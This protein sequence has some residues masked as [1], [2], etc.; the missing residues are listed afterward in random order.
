MKV[1]WQQGSVT[2]VQQGERALTR[3]AMFCEY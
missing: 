2:A 1:R 3:V